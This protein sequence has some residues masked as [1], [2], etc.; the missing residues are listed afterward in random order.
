MKTIHLIVVAFVCAL[1]KPFIV[2]AQCGALSTQNSTVNGNN[3]ILNS[4]YPG[5]GNPS[6][7]DTYLFVGTR[8]NRGSNS[9]IAAG[10]LLLIVQMQGADINT[11]NNSSYGSGIPGN[12]SGVP[13][14]NLYAGLYEYNVVSSVSGSRINFVYA[15]A[16]NYYTQSFASSAGIRRYQVIR[17]PRYNNLT[18]NGNA[19]ITAPAWNGS[20]GG[21]VVLEAANKIT[22]NGNIDVSGRGFRGGGGKQFTG[23]GPNNTSSTNAIVELKNTDYRFY[24]AAGISANTCGGA[25]GESIAGTSRYTFSHG[26]N[27]TQTQSVEGYIDGS[28]GRGAPANGGGGGTDGIPVGNNNNQYNTGGGGGGN[29]GSGGKGG[30]G[31]HSGTGTVNTYPYGGLGGAAFTEA[32]LSRIIMGGGGG[33]GTANNSTSGNEYEASGGAGGGIIILRAATYGGNGNLRANGG[34]APGIDGTP[35]T[36]NTDAGGGG[37]AGGTIVA[38]T[39]GNLAAN[40]TSIR[41]YAAGGAGG[42]AANYYDHGPGGGGGGGLIYG[43][44]NFGL[45]D[46]SGGASGRTR[47]GTQNGPLNNSFGATAGANGQVNILNGAPFL[48]NSYSSSSPCG[49]LPVTLVSL[50]GVLQP[51][52]VTLHWEI[53]DAHNFQHFEIEYSQDGIDFLYAGK[54]DYIEGKNRYSIFHDRMPSVMNYYRLKMVDIDGSFTY[55]KIISLRAQQ[56]GE[57]MLAYPNPA[58]QSVTVQVKAHE[59]TEAGIRIYN[60]L[61]SPVLHKV[62]ILQKGDNVIPLDVHYN[63][64]GMYIIEIRQKKGST[65][66][67]KLQIVKE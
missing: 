53:A 50:N 13:G 42:N 20:T 36:A 58:R 6:M 39:T 19:T 63:P 8:D 15:L 24:S 10:D 3:T 65:L 54:T 67:E 37:G 46:V 32:T 7:G 56:R 22:I 23:A 33:A 51:N 35:G 48:Y 16:N 29:A 1:V 21:V 59:T 25:K 4:Y 40:L 61:G 5:T 49:A 9:S 57:N 17:V 62:T 2:H 55:S 64:A 47:S 11:S 60:S 44:G 45:T 14:S 38:V 18:V 34:A 43:S 28:I 27:S 52:G 26:G 12:G 31:W 30:S 66:R 41:A